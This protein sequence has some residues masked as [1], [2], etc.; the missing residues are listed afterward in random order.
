MTVPT[1]K[2][3]INQTGATSAATLLVRLAWRTTCGVQVPCTRTNFFQKGS[4]PTVIWRSKVLGEGNCGTGDRPWGGSLR[5]RSLSRHSIRRRPYSHQSCE[6]TDRNSIQ[7]RRG[8]VS[9]PRG[10][11]AQRWSRNRVR[12]SASVNLELAQRKW[13]VLSREIC[14]TYP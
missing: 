8:Q 2:R 12:S 10:T 9:G 14:R 4:I 3:S 7:G 13:C 11:D 1:R 5:M 6:V